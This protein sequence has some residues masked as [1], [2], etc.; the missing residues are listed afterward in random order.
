[1]NQAEK[2]ILEE[3]RGFFLDE[4]ERICQNQKNFNKGGI[5]YAHTV[6]YAHTANPSS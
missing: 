4:S 6:F 1:M 5:F 3:I 2:L